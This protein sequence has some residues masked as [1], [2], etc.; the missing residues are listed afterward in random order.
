MCVGSSASLAWVEQNT[1]YNIDNWQDDHLQ[2][3]ESV[4]S[5]L[6]GDEI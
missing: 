6:A 2:R 3:R 4:I 1:N 5:A